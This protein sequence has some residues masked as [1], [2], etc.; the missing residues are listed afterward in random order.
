MVNFSESMFYKLPP[1]L[2][3]QVLANTDGHSSCLIV[4]HTFVNMYIHIYISSASFAAEFY[5]FDRC[6]R[7]CLHH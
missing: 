3:L 6:V 5:A 2:F 4:F 1:A 7:L